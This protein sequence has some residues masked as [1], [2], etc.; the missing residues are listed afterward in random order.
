MPND[1]AEI[2]CKTRFDYIIIGGGTAGLVVAAR[3]SEDN[4]VNVGVID[5]GELRLDDPIISIPMLSGV[6]RDN[7]TY[8]WLF[9]TA[10][11]TFLNDRVIRWPRGKVVG[12]SSSIHNHV[13]IR[14]SP[15]E[16]DD[17]E[18]LGNKG[19]NWEGLAP[20]FKK[21]ETF[22]PIPGGHA[23]L[24]KAYTTT[25]HG[26]DGPLQTTISD[27]L[28]ESNKLWIPTWNNL[29]IQTAQTGDDSILGTQFTKSSIDYTTGTRSSAL[30]AYYAPNANR[31]NLHLLSNALVSRI[32]FSGHAE[33]KL[34]ATAV[35]FTFG[36]K[37]YEVKAHVEVILCAGVVKSPTILELS[38]I[39]SGSILEANGI[40]TLIDNPGVGENLQDHAFTISSH[41]VFDSKYSLDPLS[42]SPELAEKSMEEY[43]ASKTGFFAC[44]SNAATYVSNFQI[45]DSMPEKSGL[46]D[47]YRLPGLKKQ[48]DL[49]VARL[50]NPKVPT[51]QFVLAPAY[52]AQLIPV[53]KP[54]GAKDCL[55]IMNCVSS[56]F[57][58]GSIH[59]RSADPDDHPIIDPRYLE[60]HL[61][62]DLFVK[63]S[64]YGLKCASTAPLSEAIE[65]SIL[66]AAPLSTDEEYTS[67]VKKTLGT[68]YHH[69][70]T[71]S[72]LPLEDGGVVDYNLVVYGTTNLRVVDAS[73]IPLHISGNI[74][75]TVY[76]VAEKAADIIKGTKH[77][78]KV[79]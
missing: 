54:V 31:P 58:R 37:L 60:H 13:L 65:K 36:D 16:Y 56:P 61:D 11:Q 78:C 75:W 34:T 74:Q 9:E 8:D 25:N 45:D 66:P 15:E 55:S 21:T 51:F 76:A 50:A 23:S 73:I 77:A 7:P 12:G 26:H 63:A 47:T 38:G 6:A 62:H 32:V 14:A 42:S 68:F 46:D 64:R 70:G 24:R 19:W 43:K 35:E 44:A 53:P 59:I 2:F 52:L 69:I 20:Y 4:S 22:R 57:S 33:S 28:N 17:W 71:C 49:Q 48:Y 29:G 41:Q 27:D 67:F 40:T 3:L 5:A 1:V 79:K 18:A 39:G 10:P 72:M 30:S